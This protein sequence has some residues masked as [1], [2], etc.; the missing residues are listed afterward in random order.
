MVHQQDI[1]GRRL[2]G[3][4]THLSGLHGGAVDKEHSNFSDISCNV[5]TPCLCLERQSHS[6][7]IEFT[8]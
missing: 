6:K 4:F 3:R 1:E 7:M 2:H 8:H 5:T